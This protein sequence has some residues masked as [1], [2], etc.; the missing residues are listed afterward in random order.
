[1]DDSQKEQ[2]KNYLKQLENE[3]TN[4]DETKFKEFFSGLDFKDIIKITKYLGEN[5]TDDEYNEYLSRIIPCVNEGVC[6]HIVKDSFNPFSPTVDYS[7]DIFYKYLSIYQL[8]NFI[9]KSNSKKYNIYI[10]DVIEGKIGEMLP[11]EKANFENEVR[12]KEVTPFLKRMFSYC[13]PEEVL[14]E[15]NPLDKSVNR[16][17][18]NN[19]RKYSKIGLPPNMTLGIEIECEGINS[20][21]FSGRQFLQ[22]KWRGKS[23]GSLKDGV[24]VISPIL[25]DTEENT[26]DIYRICNSIQSAG[27]SCSER[28]GGHVHIG[29]DYLTT[30]QSYEYLKQMILYCERIM[31]ITSNESGQIPR[32]GTKRY[33]GPISTQMDSKNDD[34]MYEV[35]LENEADLDNYI[36]T[37][38]SDIDEIKGTFKG[39]QNENRYKGI[40]FL[41]LGNPPEC[42]NT[43]EFRMPNGTVNPDVWI[44]NMRFFGR[45]VQK[46]EELAQIFLKESKTP[47]DLAILEQF[48]SIKEAKSEKERAEIF[49]DVLFDEDEKDTYIDRYETNSKL[50]EKKRLLNRKKF[51]Y[52]DFRHNCEQEIKNG[53]KISDFIK[54][55]KERL[56]PRIK[57]QEIE[58][59]TGER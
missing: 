44:E 52:S 26:S 30:P 32:K 3:P 9:D 46:S 59:Q 55:I 2:F 22:S 51:T 48:E 25:T 16:E 13:D 24:E 33:A 58:N 23:D 5:K 4:I 10:Y 54:E 45:V 41:N 27:L 36:D 34:E 31:Y 56:F 39:I 29:A 17:I 49:F 53:N 38:F 8:A 15:V 28:C 1:M 11:E 21:L 35:N 20:K 50:V 57:T 43:I 47:E 37:Q 6:E 42:K 12:T 18:L 7:I 19:S 40:N 14:D